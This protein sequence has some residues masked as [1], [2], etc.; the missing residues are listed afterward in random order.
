[1]TLDFQEVEAP[2]ISKQSAHVVGKVVSPPRRPPLPPG[3]I[4]GTH[5]C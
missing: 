5:F 2:T 4:P 1:M 3:E